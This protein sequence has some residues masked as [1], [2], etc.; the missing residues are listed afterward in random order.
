MTDPDEDPL[1]PYQ[2]SDAEPGTRRG[3]WRWLIITVVVLLVL[4]GG[5]AVALNSWLSDNAGKVRDS[6]A[7][8][9]R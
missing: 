9:L 3:D 1:V 2:D 4:C 8:H 7:T 5:A 6:V